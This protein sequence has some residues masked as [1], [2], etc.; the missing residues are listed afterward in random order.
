[1][2][3]QIMSQAIADYIIDVLGSTDGPLDEVKLFVR[4]A[5]GPGQIPQDHYPF[6]EIFVAEELE[7]PEMTGVYYGQTYTGVITFTVTLAHETSA[8]Q[9]VKIG[10]RVAHV[11]SYDMVK[12]LVHAAIFELQKEE[13][14]DMGSLGVVDEVVIQFTVSGPRIFG[15]DRELRSNNWANF[16]VFPFEVETERQRL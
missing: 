8:D 4:G 14:R 6:C 1:M 15:I 2:T 9:L 10:E 16:G 11:P 5:L 3:N 12:E 7:G 13:H